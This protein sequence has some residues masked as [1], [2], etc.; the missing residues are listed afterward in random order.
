MKGGVPGVRLA[1]T[2]RPPGRAIGSKAQGGLRCGRAKRVLAEATPAAVND[3]VFDW[4]E[5]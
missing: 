3:L 5:H 4:P 1:P 2:H